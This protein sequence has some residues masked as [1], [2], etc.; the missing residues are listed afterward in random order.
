[1]RILIVEDDEKTCRLLLRGLRESGLEADACYD[2]EDGLAKALSGAYDLLL[3]DIMMPVRD[4]L[5]L[6][7]EL[8]QQKNKT[9]VI[10][11][12]A[13]ESAADQV[14]GLELGA[15]GYL[16]KPVAFNE[17]L[18]RIEAVMRRCTSEGDLDL[19]YESLTLRAKEKSVY[20]D[21]KPLP[22]NDREF[23]VLQQFML[24]PGQGLTAS[25][26]A[27]RLKTVGDL[28]DFNGLVESLRQRIDGSYDRKLL[29]TVDGFVHILR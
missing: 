9:P 14:A 16:V 25:F 8:R 12:T 6:L 29:H 22:L 19:K 4:G 13:R 21:N 23:S 7:R 11:L 24:F 17:L 15:D 27:E 3:L 2:G 20:R 18:A 5:S 26:F 28:P 10:F 1:M